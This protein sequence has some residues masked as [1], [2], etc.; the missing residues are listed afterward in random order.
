VGVIAGGGYWFVSACSPAADASALTRRRRA[1][2]SRGFRPHHRER[3]NDPAQSS[4]EQRPR[5]FHQLRNLLL[6]GVLVIA[7]TAVTV[8]VLFKLLN[9]VDNL[10]GR[11]LRF[12]ALDYHRVPGL[13]LL[14]VLLIL[15]IVGWL[16][17]WIGSKQIGALWDQFPHPA[18]RRRHSLRLDQ[19]DGRGAVHQPQG[20]GVPPGRAGAVAASRSLPDRIRDRTSGPEI[21]AR[22]GSDFES[23]FV[24][25]TPNPAS[26]FMHYA[27]RSALVYLDWTVEDA[28]RVIVSGGV[29][30]PGSDRPIE[31]TT[32]PGSSQ[33]PPQS[34]AEALMALLRC[35]GIV[36]KSYALGD[37]SR[38]VVAFTRE[39]GM[40]RMVAKGARKLPSRFG[41]A[42]EPL[43]RS[44]YVIYHKPDRDLQLLSQA[45]CVRPT[46]SE[47]PDL[48]RLAHAEAAIELVDRLVWGEEPHPELFDLLVATLARMTVASLDAL[49]AV[50]AAFQLQFASLLGYQPRV[51][52]CAQCAGH[53]SGD[54][55]SRRSAADCCATGARPPSP[56]RSRSRPTRWRR[57]C[58]CSTVRSTRPATCRG[59]PCRRLLKVIEAYL[60]AQ[61]SASRDCARSRCC[62]RSR[63]AEPKKANVA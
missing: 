1:L 53:V 40:V 51:D 42:L 12:A 8:W 57:W 41:F 21:R 5:F 30:Q 50:T 59:G 55:C 62:A 22:L 16:A 7:P 35:E 18:A 49:P 36:L 6:T 13:G 19:V 39:L 44:R 46:G 45:E 56:A 37:T 17:S 29:V 10:L 52:T 27:P 3:P 31:L 25:H 24:P 47:L 9:F 33:T 32:P 60:R 26:G 63:P 43:S 38:I 15:L 11:Y 14:A 48:A 2:H 54:A 4:N 23:V 20:A 28:L 34:A 61:F 58:C